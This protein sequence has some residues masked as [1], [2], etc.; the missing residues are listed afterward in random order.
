MFILV[1]QLESELIFSVIEHRY[2]YI[3][4]LAEERKDL[5]QP[6]FLVVGIIRGWVDEDKLSKGRKR[7]KTLNCDSTEVVFTQSRE[8]SVL[9]KVFTKS[10]TSFPLVL[11][12][13]VMR[14]RLYELFEADKSYTRETN[15]GSKLTLFEVFRSS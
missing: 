14:Q 5:R 11:E 1:F 9:G 2:N 4:K 15:H 12:H 7:A 13:L 8:S 10:N 3:R 6:S